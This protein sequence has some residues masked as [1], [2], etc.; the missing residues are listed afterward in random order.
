MRV[1]DKMQRISVFKFFAIELRMILMV[2]L[3]NGLRLNVNIPVESQFRTS[4][5]MAIVMLVLPG[6]IYVIVAIELCMTLTLLF[7]MGQG[8]M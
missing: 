4:S 7:S 5:F 8:K 2:H 1:C 6:S 3:Y